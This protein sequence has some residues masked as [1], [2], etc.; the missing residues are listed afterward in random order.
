MKT[1]IITGANGFIGSYITYHLLGQSWHVCALGRSK[2]SSS[3]ADR[4]SAALLQVAES[5]QPGEL[6]SHEVDLNAASLRL[7][8]CFPSDAV[9]QETVLFHVAGDTRF[10]P[11]NPDLQRQFNI[12]AAVSVLKALDGRIGRAIYVSTAYVA[13]DRRGLIRESELDAGQQFH[14]SYE[15]SKFDAEI[16]VSEFCRSRGI[17]LVIVRPSIIINDR[18]TGR[19]SAFTHLNALVE[20][21]S[22]IQE[23]FGIADGQ[24]VSSL[25][26]LA[27]DPDARPNLAPIDSIIPPLLHIAASAEAPGQVFHLCHPAPQS[28]AEIVDLIALAIGIKGKVG[29]R[30]VDSLSQPMSHT[31][32]MILRSLKVYAPYLNSRCQFDLSNSRSVVPAYD[33]HFSGLDLGYLQKVIRFQRQRRKQRS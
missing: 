17:P 16:A 11:T 1:A 9:P 20:V 19:S 5:S 23:H 10:T 28:N 3:W 33:G 12:Q 7:D 18:Q 26:R 8:A 14:N 31:E 15:R 2:L 13:G 30:F 6:V 4:V 21:V 24:V 29:L 25:I 27:A 22:R 32:E